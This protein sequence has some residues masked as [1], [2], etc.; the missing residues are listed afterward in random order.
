MDSDHFDFDLE[1]MKKAVQG[2]SIT[3]PDNIRT[4][5]GFR[6]WL[7][8]EGDRLEV[9]R[10]VKLCEEKSYTMPSGL[11]REERRAWAKQ[12]LAAHEFHQEAQRILTSR[13][14][15]RGVDLDLAGLSLEQ[16][17][18]K[19]AKHQTAVRWYQVIVHNNDPE[20]YPPSAYWDPDT[21]RTQY[22]F[23]T[24]PHEF[25]LEVYRMFIEKDTA[26]MT[27]QERDAACAELH[28][29]MGLDV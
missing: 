24:M 4:A 20:T 28:N 3:P 25:K 16:V 18:D 23:M 12:T 17:Q 27:P 14:K 2:E 15:G 8:D 22:E 26:H 5:D 1:R 21:V 19:L 10:L 13:G 11:S 7:L 29:Y 9:E 6:E